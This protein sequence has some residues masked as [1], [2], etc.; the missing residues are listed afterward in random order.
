M[1]LA[2]QQATSEFRLFDEA[3]S[4]LVARSLIAL[5]QISPNDADIL[6]ALMKQ[7]ADL[8]AIIWQVPSLRTPQ[9]LGDSERDY[10]TLIAHLC[11]SDG[12]EGDL[13]LPVKAT[14]QRTFLMSK[15]QFLRAF[16][17]A[18]DALRERTSDLRSL[19]IQL[20]EELAQSIYTLMAEDLLLALMR[21]PGL[22]EATKRVAA[23]ELCKIWDNATLE[24]DDLFPMLE[25]AW[26]ARNR[27]VANI[28][29]LLGASEYF[30]LVR[31]DC[32]PQ[33]LDY[34]AR[35]EVSNTENQAFI[36]FLFGIT[37]EELETLKTRMKLEGID[38]ADEHW[39]SKVLGRA[40]EHECAHDNAD[41]IDPISLYRSYQRRQLAADFR[42]LSGAPGPRRTAEA[43]LIIYLLNQKA[44][45]TATP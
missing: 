33:F 4:E 21:K 39:A 17:T 37:T 8:N 30:R 28:G 11:R 9:T 24:I 13:E 5:A 2:R 14:L 41:E 27:I 29:S 32:A 25:S 44:K 31:E 26:H 6:S 34:F 20:R 45:R 23:E 18:T 38:A 7:L 42:I 22:K 3:E 40:L 16:V 12:L 35:D 19:N 43:Y 36:E 15:I 10:E 1:S